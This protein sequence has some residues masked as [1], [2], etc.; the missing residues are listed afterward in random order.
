MLKVINHPV[1]LV[2]FALGV[3]VP[4]GQ[5][6]TVS[7]ADGAVF[8]CPLIPDVAVE[9]VD[10]VGFLLPDP[11]QFVNTGF[12][13]C[14]PDGQNGKF[15]LQIITVDNA[16]FFYGMG[17]SA[18]VP[19]GTHLLVGIPDAVLQDITAVLLKNFICTLA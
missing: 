13:I 6:I 14:A 17:R 19:A 4:D 7:F 2:K 9:I 11:Q 10:I 16:E 5:L 18:V 12:E 1:H 8:I 15:P 3:L